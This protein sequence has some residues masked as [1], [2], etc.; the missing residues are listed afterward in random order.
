LYRIFFLWM[1]NHF[2]RGFCWNGDVSS[3]GVPGFAASPRT[4]WRDIES[5]FTLK[6]F[7]LSNIELKFVNQIAGPSILVQPIP[8]TTTNA[9]D[10]GMQC[11]SS[12]PDIF[13]PSI[14]KAWNTGNSQ[15]LSLNSVPIQDFFSP[16]ICLSYK[17]RTRT[18]I[19]MAAMEI[20]LQRY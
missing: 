12:G 17:S 9:A 20:Q 6:T 4:C 2:L 11:S 3:D 1:K 8:P 13:S 18:K 15:S 7:L 19:Q 5:H 14:P 16:E 10:G